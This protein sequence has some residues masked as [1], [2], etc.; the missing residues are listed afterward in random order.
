M[1]VIFFCKPFSQTN[2][3]RDVHGPCKNRRMG[4][5]R[6]IHGCKGKHFGFVELNRLT[7][8]QII[9]CH[10]HR[11]VCY[12]T[13]LPGIGKDTEK[14]VRYILYISCTSLHISIIHGCKHLREVISCCCNGILCVDF[15]GGNNILNRIHII[16]IHQHHLMYFKDCR[17]GFSHIFHCLVIQLTELCD[18]SL[19]G[20]LKTCRLCFGIVYVIPSYLL[21]LSFIESNLP[22]GYATKNTFTT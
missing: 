8:Y 10:D 18:C 1:P 12:N 14:T 7:W 2:D 6:T 19:L 9:C 22:D 15:L 16:Q 3:G 4:V 11:F 21:F 20:S 5:C 17:I 13:A